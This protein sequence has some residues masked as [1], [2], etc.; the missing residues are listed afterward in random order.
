VEP[1]DTILVH[2]KGRR[3]KCT[4]EPLRG[5][6]GLRFID[7]EPEARVSAE[8][9]VVL[10]VDAPVISEA[11]AGRPLM[12]L[13]ATWRLLLALKRSLH[14]TFVCR[15][16]PV[17]LGTAYPR[18]SKLEPDPEA[19][20]ASVEALYAAPVLLG[21][22]DDTLLESYRWRDAFLDRCREAGIF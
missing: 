8:G 5:R 10:A 9:H 16:L 17:D 6:P 1:R 22:R 2:Y 14:G 4:L 19:G 18:R 13:D 21:H 12:L 11:D 20:L 7:F 15:S 3:S